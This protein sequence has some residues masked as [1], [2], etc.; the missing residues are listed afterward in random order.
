MKLLLD[1]HAFLWWDSE[2]DRLP[3]RV[4]EAIESPANSVY[5]SIAS[6]WETQIKAQLGKLKL[7]LPLPQLILD[8]EKAN[9]LHILLTTREDIF[10][11]ESLP[12]LH[13]DPFD[14]MIV[15]QALR[16]EFE[17]VT[18]D[19]EVGSYGVKVFW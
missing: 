14:R 2:R 15:A 1:T 9:N 4:L 3:P 10:A 12:P 18:H 7:R 17:V 16:G 13:R 5:L 19:D 6:I 11:L 8:Q